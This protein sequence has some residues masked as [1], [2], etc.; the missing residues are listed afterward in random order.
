MKT[1][2]EAGAAVEHGVYRTWLKEHFRRAV[3]WRE[4]SERFLA[5]KR[6]MVPNYEPMGP[7]LFTSQGGG[8]VG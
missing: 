1:R 5:F 3:E 8:T 4:V 7:L 6:Q 2:L